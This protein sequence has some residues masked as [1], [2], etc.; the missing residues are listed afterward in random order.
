MN[1]F[2][3]SNLEEKYE[4]LKDYLSGLKSAAIAFSGGVDSTFLLFAAKEALGNRAIAITANSDLF[5]ER[6]HKEALDFAKKYHMKQIVFDVDE[7]E[8]EG[9]ANNPENRCYLCKKTIFSQ[10]KKLAKENGA[11][12]VAE[13][14]NMDDNGDYRP[15]MKAI[16]E[17][18]I[19]SPLRQVGLYKEEIRELSKKLGLPTWEK[20]SFACLASR[21]VYGEKITREKL[22]IVGKAEQFLL[23]LGFRQVRVRLHHNIARIETDSFELDRFLNKEMREL[24]N[25]RLKEL[26]FQY[27]SLDLQG[28]RTGSM[29]EV[30]IE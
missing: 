19:K 18:E 3:G 26:G 16:A 11:L 20:P 28:Y 25:N 15:G 29:N 30:I 27:I 7:F 1:P 5:P 6:E 4:R 8:I 23:D 2:G 10:I 17:L 13:G 14:S 12:Y 21:F 9:F 24:V 22:Q